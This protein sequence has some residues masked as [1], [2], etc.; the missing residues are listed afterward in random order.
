LTYDEIGDGDD[1]LKMV[2]RYITNSDSFYSKFG[3]HQE[4]ED[5]YR[6]WLRN[7]FP[8]FQAGK[9]DLSLPEEE[10]NIYRY[11][12][13]QSD[14]PIEYANKWKGAYRGFG[15]IKEKL[16]ILGI[17]FDDI[18]QAIDLIN[19]EKERIEQ[20]IDNISQQVPIKLQ[21][22]TLA[23]EER[24][25]IQPTIEQRVDE[26]AS[27]NH[28]LHEVVPTLPMDKAKVV[29]VPTE[30]LPI[31]PSKKDI[32]KEIEEAVIVDEVEEVE[33]LID[34]SNLIENLK[35]GMVVRFNFGVKK[36]LNKVLDL[37]FE[38]GEFVLYTAFENSN[39]DVQQDEEEVIS[40]SEV[41]EFYINHN[42]KISEEFYDD[43]TGEEDE[44]EII[45]TETEEKSK[46]Q[47]YQDIIE[48][49]E[50]ALELETNKEKIKMY[51]DIIEGYE[52]ALELEN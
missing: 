29:E 3:Y 18:P 12:D 14:S 46:A 35:N 51:Q 41:I 25:V 22:F 15:K 7:N 42:D 6:G 33:N 19:A 27:Y 47:M 20:E 43:G 11:L 38:D 13:Y 32:E 52:L 28:I 49:Y 9:Y 48:G 45:S 44:E 17:E 50:L 30:K 24:M 39:G 16:K 26:F 40:E 31:K 34:T 21:E 23:K 1:L 10:D 36:K 8:R 4:L 2:N 37:F 5:I